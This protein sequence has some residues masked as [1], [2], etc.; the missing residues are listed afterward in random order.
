MQ[1]SYYYFLYLREFDIKF[2]RYPCSFT[3]YFSKHTKITAL[4]A[5]VDKILWQS[6]F[7]FLLCQ[8]FSHMQMIYRHIFKV[9]FI[10][11]FYDQ[12]LNYLMQS[13]E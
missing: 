3:H 1:L 4:S 10:F 5:A 6:E 13:M 9:L 8:Y 12:Q 11:N 7:Y 2:R